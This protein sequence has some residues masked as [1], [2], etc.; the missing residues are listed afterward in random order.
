MVLWNDGRSGPYLER[1]GAG[2][3]FWREL[4]MRDL[5]AEGLGRLLMLRE[6]YPQYFVDGFIHCGAGELTFHRLTQE[7]RQDPGHAIQIGA[8]DARAQQLDPRPFDLIGLDLDFI[9]PLRQGHETAPLSNQAANRYG[10]PTGIPVAGPYIDQEAGYL[11]A[12]LAGARPLQC[13]LGTAW[14]GNFELPRGAGGGSEFQLPLPPLAGG[15]RLVVQPLLTGNAFWDWGCNHLAAQ[16]AEYHSR[17]ES[18]NSRLRGD[19]VP[20]EGLTAI[21]YLAQANPLAPNAH[22]AAAFS[23]IGPNVTRDDLLRA[24]V[25]GMCCE[26]RRVFEHVAQCGAADCVVIG[27]GTCNSAAFRKFI[28]A[29][30]HP[31]SVRRQMD[32]DLAGARGCLYAF[33]RDVAASRNRAVKP[34]HP[35]VLAGARRAYDDYLTLHE[36]VCGGMPGAGVFRCE[37]PSA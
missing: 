9:A 14:V 18:A 8:Y 20:P 37:P 19:Y 1:L 4:H 12:Q 36:R 3:D 28:A 26:L 34:P 30:F 16:D 17:Y 25:A 33:S 2:P 5:P 22:G 11:S 31:L 21:P 6:R 10:L 15:E 27:G 24:L 13:S 23:G 29:L 32:P 35:T 7:W